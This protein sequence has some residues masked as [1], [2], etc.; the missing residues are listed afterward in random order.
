MTLEQLRHFCLGLPGVTEDVKWEH[1]LCFCVGDKMFC[2]TGFDVE[3]PVSLKASLQDF[4]DLCEQQGIIPAP[5]LARAKWICIKERNAI[6]PAQWKH[7]I[8]TSYE[9]IAAGLTKKRRKEL[10]IE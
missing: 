2:V 5:Y 3:A 8:E 7:L 9:L 4:D 10:G 6:T 1:D